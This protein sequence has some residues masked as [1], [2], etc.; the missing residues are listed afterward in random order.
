MSKKRDAREFARLLASD[1][2]FQSKVKRRC[3]DEL[4]G[5]WGAHIPCTE[6]IVELA[7]EDTAAPA[8][9]FRATFVARVIGQMG[10]V[11]LPPPLEVKALPE[12]E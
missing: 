12:G 10:E 7:T 3:M 6:M 2:V 9:E 4:D 1:P 5:K 8:C 11:T